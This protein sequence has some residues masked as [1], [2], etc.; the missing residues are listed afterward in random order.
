MKRQ[1]YEIEDLKQLVEKN[2][3]K[4][5]FDIQSLCNHYSR[6]RASIYRIFMINFHCSPVHFIEDIRLNT[7]KQKIEEGIFV[8]KEIAYDVGYIDPKYFCKRFKKKYLVPPLLY[9]NE[10]KNTIKDKMKCQMF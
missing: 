2:F 9:Q 8:I 7:A 3:H 4:P 1:V 6:S 5:E 10:C